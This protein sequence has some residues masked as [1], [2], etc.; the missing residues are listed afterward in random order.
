MVR[1]SLCLALSIGILSCLFLVARRNGHV[2]GQ[3]VLLEC[4]DDAADDAHEGVPPPRSRL[5]A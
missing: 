2:A 5:V 3:E 4:T 1:T